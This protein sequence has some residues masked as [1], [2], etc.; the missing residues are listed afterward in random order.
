MYY[1]YTL[2]L[3]CSVKPQFEVVNIQQHS[4]EV[5]ITQ[6]ES[7]EGELQVTSMKYSV[8]EC[9]D[10]EGRNQNENT[11]FVEFK[12]PYYSNDQRG[13][14]RGQPKRKVRKLKSHRRYSLMMQVEY[15]ENN[16][17]ESGPIM[18][19]TLPY[20]GTVRLNT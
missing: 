20:S 11:Q 13:S 18:F 15:G 8:R 7:T 9:G 14:E 4:A 2:I 5:E 19:D 12:P 17:V 1:I 10:V 16:Y 3:S 6:P